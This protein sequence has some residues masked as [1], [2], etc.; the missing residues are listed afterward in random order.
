[1]D[2]IELLARRSRETSTVDPTPRYIRLAK[3]IRNM[4]EDGHL[5]ADEAIPSE[6]MM[7]DA[8]QLSRVTVRRAMSKL[9]EEGWVEQR[10]GSGTFVSP[11]LGRIEQPLSELTG[12][13]E[14]MILHGRRP[15]SEWLDRRLDL[16]T[17]H[18]AMTLGLSPGE[19]IARLHRLR[20]ADDEP[21]AI[22][23]ATVPA[24]C[25]PSIET[26]TSSLYEAMSSNGCLP[27]KAFQ[28]MQAC[29]LPEAEAHHL[30]LNVGEPVLYIERLSR[31]SSGRA[32]E[33]TRSYYRADR[34][35]FV[36]ELSIQH[37]GRR[38]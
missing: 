3:I 27:D 7:V 13:H 17:T 15:T 1:M 34:Y 11:R 10:H 28:R 35:D 33:F 26:V 14:D 19:R 31:L 5:V 23:Y 25:L 4:I 38:Q 9:A 16:P 32:V 22:E 36:A 2:S 30:R 12:F 37:H 18:E 20:L 8:T 6:R 29:R 21:L 24:S